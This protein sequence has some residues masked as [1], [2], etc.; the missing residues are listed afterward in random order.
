MKSQNVV[1]GIQ[2]TV[3]DILGVKVLV[4]C[5]FVGDIQKLFASHESERSYITML[6]STIKGEKYIQNCIII[7]RTY[8]VYG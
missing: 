3:K 5:D 4:L 1:E 8:D 6:K 2:T 7:S